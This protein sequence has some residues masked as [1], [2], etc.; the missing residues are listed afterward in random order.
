MLIWTTLSTRGYVPKCGTYLESVSRHRAGIDRLAFGCVGFDHQ[1]VAKIPPGWE[2]YSVPDVWLDERLGNPGNGCIQ[3]G[4]FLPALGAPPDAVIVCTDADIVMQRPL[5]AAECQWLHDWPAGAVGI[6]PNA[7]AGDTLADEATRIQPRVPIAELAARFWPGRPAPLC[8]N[9]G[10]LVARAATWY[11]LWTRYL[12]LF[13]VTRALFDHI[14][15]QQWTINL[16]IESMQRIVLPL[17]F[18]A[19]RHYGHPTGCTTDVDGVGRCQGEPI[20]LAHHWW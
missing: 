9:A 7:W 16:A 1:A 8:G 11:E 19:H 4:N 6:G 5:T 12:A 15:V 3:H 2:P 20:L 17:S 10:V 14:A 13:P 18:H